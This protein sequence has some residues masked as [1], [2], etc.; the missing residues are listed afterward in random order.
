M[1]IFAVS[2]RKYAASPTIWI[3]ANTLA[4]GRGLRR[5]NVLQERPHGTLQLIGL[6]VKL[7]GDRKNLYR[8]LSCLAD[9]ASFR[10]GI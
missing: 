5:A 9:G 1:G 7:I 2:A 8:C 4:R 6:F 10:P 3:A